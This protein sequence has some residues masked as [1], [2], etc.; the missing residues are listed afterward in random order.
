MKN[1]SGCLPVILVL[2]LNLTVGTWSIVEILSWF[3]KSISIIA[4]AVIGLFAGEISVPVAIVG[5]ILKVC[6]VF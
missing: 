2:A 4:C 3:G 1:Y 6:G 5:W